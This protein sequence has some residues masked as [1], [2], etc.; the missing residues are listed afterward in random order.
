MEHANVAVANVAQQAATEIASTEERLAEWQNGIARQQETLA[1]RVQQH[2]TQIE[3]R[4][5][6]TTEQLSSILS[7]LAPPPANPENPRR[8]QTR[9]PLRKTKQ[10]RNRRRKGG[11]R[12]AGFKLG[13]W[14]HPRF[15]CGHRRLVAATALVSST[16]PTPSATAK[17]W[18]TRRDISL[19]RRRKRRS[20]VS[21]L[22][23]HRV[24][25]RRAAHHAVDADRS[26]HAPAATAAR[27]RA[28]FPVSFPTPNAPAPAAPPPQHQVRQTPSA[29]GTGAPSP[30]HADAPARRIERH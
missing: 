17:R 13:D 29:N 6:E 12:I 21:M 28:S 7:R 10:R 30:P 20:I 26:R 25:H 19:S 27:S 15:S 24:F 5:K 4:L 18:R 2:E 11:E 22:V 23:D 3:Q 16:R 1:A 8:P 9:P 14:R